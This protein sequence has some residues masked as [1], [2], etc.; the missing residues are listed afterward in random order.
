MLRVVLSIPKINFGA[1]F[2]QDTN[3]YRPSMGSPLRCWAGF[4]PTAFVPPIA[5]SI[6][7]SPG[8][9]ISPRLAGA[10]ISD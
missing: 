1:V 7:L 6:Y 2:S 4:V 3:T 8:I 10:S 5:S 9:L